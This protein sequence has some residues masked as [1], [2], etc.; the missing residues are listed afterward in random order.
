MMLALN[1]VLDHLDKSLDVSLE[2]LFGL[3]RIKSISTDPDFKGDVR[4]AAE[5]LAE[6]SENDR[7]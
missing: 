4:K 7:L 2:R 1:P 3:L 6:D 5:W